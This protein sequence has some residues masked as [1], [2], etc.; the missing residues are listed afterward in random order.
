M[1]PGGLGFG[2]GFAL[3]QA[4][5]FMRSSRAF[6]APR[7]GSN[8]VRISWNTTR[9]T[10]TT[11]S[12]SIE[13]LIVQINFEQRKPGAWIVSF[14]ML[15]DESQQALTLATDIFSGVMAAVQEFLD[16]REPDLLIF[17]ASQREGLADAY[18]VY[19]QREEREFKRRGYRI[20]LPERAG[21]II[22]F[23]LQRAN[24]K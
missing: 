24:S 13:S 11:A 3:G 8:P 16:L 5:L 6:A 15:E 17:P 21:P 19:L 18:E 9:Q 1:V 23:R 2:C 20:E 10:G 14:T 22:E 12:F 4:R 7:I